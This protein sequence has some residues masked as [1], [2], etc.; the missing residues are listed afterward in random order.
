M[1]ESVGDVYVAA[2]SCRRAPGALQLAVERGDDAVGRN[3]PE[4]VVGIV[5]EVVIARGVYRHAVWGRQKRLIGRSVVAVAMGDAGEGKDSEL[6]DSL[7]EG[8][9]GNNRGPK[10]GRDPVHQHHSK[11]NYYALCCGPCASGCCVRY[12]AGAC[13]IGTQASSKLEKLPYR[14][15]K[16][17]HINGP[18]RSSVISIRT[19]RILAPGWDVSTAARVAVGL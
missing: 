12:N 1:V 13:P 8:N 6:R 10:N 11:N 14:Y 3:A 15:H 19:A 9:G 2:R 18:N 16:L 17:R 5:G 4:Q 7:S